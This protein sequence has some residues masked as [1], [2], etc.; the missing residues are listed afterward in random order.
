MNLFLGVFARTQNCFSLDDL[1]YL[2]SPSPT[3][4]FFQL[5]QLARIV[6]HPITVFSPLGFADCSHN[7]HLR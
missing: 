6:V 2:R 5:T 4:F 1:V 3:K 7:A